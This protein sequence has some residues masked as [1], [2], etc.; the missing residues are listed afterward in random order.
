[1]CIIPLL[2]VR[3]RGAE[4]VGIR[5]PEM[6]GLPVDDGIR[7]PV[8]CKKRKKL[9]EVTLKA[10]LLLRK[11]VRIARLSKLVKRPRPTAVFKPNFGR[12]FFR[13][14]LP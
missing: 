11:S 2:D 7:K 12:K 9:R 1:M 13:K 14:F 8:D 5:I 10:L 3:T 6:G 4:D